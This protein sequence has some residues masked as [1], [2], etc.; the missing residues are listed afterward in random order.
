VASSSPDTGWLQKPTDDFEIEK[1]KQP[2]WREV[3]RVAVWHDK[4]GLI[5]NEDEYNSRLLAD[6]LVALVGGAEH[7]VIVETPYLVL[8]ER[9]QTLLEELRRKK[10]EM[11][12]RFLTNSL[13]STDTW[14]AYAGFQ[15]Q[16]R[17]MLGDLRL[18]LHL[19][20]PGSLRERSGESSKTSSLHSK[21]IIVDE[22]KTAIG[23]YNWDP[24]SGIWNAEIMVVIDDTAFAGELKQYM[25]P[26][27]RPE[28]SWV[29]AELQQPIGLEQLDAVGSTVNAI[30]SEIVGVNAWP[31]TNTACFEYSG[32]KVLS[33]Y[34]PDFHDHYTSVGSYP[35]VSIT[36]RKRI[37]TNLLQP[38]SGT[39]APTL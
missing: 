13:A 3:D 34:H 15:N 10:P 1:K 36:A 17:T 16:L 26:L 30:L 11:P 20:K 37:L 38:I 8:S 9:T 6:K 19:K 22:Q 23:S 24:R 35:E 25:R 29:V 5:G 27:W 33:P 12:I 32:S 31:L 7:S 4:P 14:Q 39:L 28:F 2:Y 21:T 18:L